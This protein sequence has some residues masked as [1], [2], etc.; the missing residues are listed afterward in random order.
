MEFYPEDDRYSEALYRLAYI[1]VVQSE[2]DSARTL[3]GNLLEQFPDNKWRFSA[4]TWKQTLDNLVEAKAKTKTKKV[5]IEKNNKETAVLLNKCE[6]EKNE[7][8]SRIKKLESI[9]EGEP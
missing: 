1:Q 6:E 3:F 2:Y 9:I 5:Y 4:K 7:L 8:R